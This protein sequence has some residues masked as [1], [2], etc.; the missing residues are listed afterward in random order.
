MT[1][2]EFSNSVIRGANDLLEMMD[3]EPNKY[4]KIAHVTRI[5]KP[6]LG[7][8]GTYLLYVD[9]YVRAG[10]VVFIGEKEHPEIDLTKLYMKKD[11]R[12][13]VVSVPGPL[14]PVFENRLIHRIT[15]QSDMRFLIRRIREFYS[16]KRISFTVPAPDPLPDIELNLEYPLSD[17]QQDAVDSVLSSPVSYV[18][19]APGTGKTRAVLAVCLLRYITA[20]KRVLLLAPT[21]NAAEQGLRAILEVLKQNG[22]PLTKVYRLGTATYEF[23]KDYPEVVGD[24]SLEQYLEE[25]SQ[26]I[27]LLSKELSDIT[28][29]KAKLHESSQQIERIQTVQRSVAD[30][31]SHIGAMKNTLESSSEELQASE[32]KVKKCQLSFDRAAEALAE[33]DKRIEEYNAEITDLEEK[34]N[35][36]NWNIWRHK[37]RIQLKKTILKLKDQKQNILLTLAPYIAEKEQA[38]Q[39]LEAAKASNQQIVYERSLVQDDIDRA[40]C[41]VLHDCGLIDLF[42][43]LPF[44]GD[45]VLASISESLQSAQAQHDAFSAVAL[46]DEET[47]KS[48]IASINEELHTVENS[49]KLKQYRNAQLI[50]ATFDTAVGK[51]PPAED[52]LKY[53]H[54]FIDEAGYAPMAKG[55][56]AFSC[57][58]PVAFFGDH[59]Q[60]PPI[61]EM[62]AKSIKLDHHDVTLWSIPVIAYS[63]L[64]Q[65]QVSRITSLL[66][67]SEYSYA[68]L[69]Y[70]PLLTSYRFGPELADILDRHIYGTNGQFQGVAERPF[71][72][73]VL[74][75]KKTSSDQIHESRNEALEI[76]SFLV[77]NP[78]ADEDYIILA[79]YNI[80]IKRLKSILPSEKQNILTVHR[81]QGMEWDT[82][83]L[84]VSDTE[85]AYFVNSKLQ[86]GSQVLTTALSRAKSRLVIVCDVDF[87]K[88]QDGQ[89]ITD[90]VVSNLN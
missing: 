72:C 28:N 46:R 49:A 12:Y 89:L 68:M 54:V 11:K 79:P 57:G 84:S 66:D 1:E 3:A 47:V 6:E 65:C 45:S 19:G 67:R 53:A 73:V 60:L 90:L 55:M 15:L 70:S 64:F 38:E 2:H 39:K 23:A 9:D 21:N 58:C 50:A 44:D 52:M 42:P 85:R 14:T 8:F 7:A 78:M 48:E 36:L 71:E 43:V 10:A 83:I 37:E 40:I 13:A 30:A 34:K 29:H 4:M 77:N 80:Q 32:D 69:S 51:I 88:K 76:Q 82:V 56:I 86:I 75:G 18:W 27:S 17:A 24:S 81:S 87:W 74:N 16:E 61:C 22:I 62:K 26:R 20:G 25:I 59:Y 35:R 33:R 5:E 63:E 41:E 31:V